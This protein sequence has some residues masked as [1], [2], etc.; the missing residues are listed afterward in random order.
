MVEFI[1]YV[2][3]LLLWWRGVR[4]E[5]ILVG[6]FNAKNVL[7]SGTVTDEKGWTLEERLADVRLL[8]LNDGL[9][10]TFRSGSLCSFQ[11]VTF[12]LEVWQRES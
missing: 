12:A 9:V 11:D 1:D 2:D 7:W 8:C 4:K 3:G 10:P 6:D 5:L